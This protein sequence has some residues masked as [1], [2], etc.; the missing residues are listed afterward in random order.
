[1]YRNLGGSGSSVGHGHLEMKF[2]AT[3]K[4]APLGKEFEQ[5]ADRLALSSIK[6]SI[7]K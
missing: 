3:T 6:F 7:W 4:V 5:I 2:L 1:M